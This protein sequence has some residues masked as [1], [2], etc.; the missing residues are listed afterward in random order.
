MLEI[1]PNCESCGRDLPP[2]ST[3][4]MICSFECTYCSRCAETL[5]HNTCPNC[6]GGFE[7]RPIRTEAGLKDQPASTDKT[8]PG[9]DGESH[10]KFLRMYRGVPPERR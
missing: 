6:G 10:L 8:E 7:R 3:E 9:I 4:A 5:L 1:K 2:N